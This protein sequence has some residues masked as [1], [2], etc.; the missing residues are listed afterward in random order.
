LLKAMLTSQDGSLAATR[1]LVNIIRQWQLVLELPAPESVVLTSIR[2]VQ[3]LLHLRRHTLSTAE[4]LAL[5]P[6]ERLDSITPAQPARRDGTNTWVPGGDGS[7]GAGSKRHDSGM[8]EKLLLR[9]DY[10]DTKRAG[11]FA[12]QAGRMTSAIRILLTGT[13]PLPPVDPLAPN[14]VRVRP[15]PLP[16]L[17]VF[18]V[19]HFTDVEAWSI[20]K[21]LRPLEGLR[22][23]LSKYF[24]EVVVSAMGGG[25]ECSLPAIA[26][27]FG[28]PA[29]L[30]E[31]L[32]IEN[33]GRRAALIVMHGVQTPPSSVNPGM[34][35]IP[36][37]MVYASA[38][39][40]MATRE[41]FLALLRVACLRRLSGGAC[42]RWP[43]PALAR[44]LPGRGHRQALPQRRHGRPHS[45]R[46]GFDVPYAHQGRP[47]R[48]RH[49]PGRCLLQS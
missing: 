42:R 7:K 9:K 49:S 23:H 2:R 10:I 15:A 22:A 37:A 27:A 3:Q 20:D 24:G 36:K 44:R 48:V 4:V 31:N 16:P 14:A 6:A 26:T 28:E 35:V 33:D 46:Q 1:S 38:Y 5:P 25:F 39:H 32:D 11:L 34:P 17:L 30:G 13:L 29:K 19:I 43:L 18:H 12:I 47:H 40:L 45:G 8:T 41:I 21:D